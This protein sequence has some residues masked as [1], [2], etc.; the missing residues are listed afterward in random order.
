MNAYLP[1]YP[2]F[3]LDMDN[4]LTAFNAAVQALGHEDG[5]PLSA[6]DEAKKA[7][8]KAIEGA[9]E[10]TAKSGRVGA[11]Y[12]YEL[13]D[14]IKNEPFYVGKGKQKGNRLDRPKEH[15]I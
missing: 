8:Y 10:S 12:V 1:G 13:W 15:F 2:K 9:G 11:F 4:V 7:M 6:S 14:P 5:L 3:F